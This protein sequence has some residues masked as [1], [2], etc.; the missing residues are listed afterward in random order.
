M[1]KTPANN[2]ANK[3]MLDADASQ[4]HHAEIRSFAD[5]VRHWAVARP[6]HVA[7]KH[8]DLSTTYRELDR[9]SSRIANA[10]IERGFPPGTNAGYLGKNSCLFWGVWFGAVKAR[11]TMAPFNWRCS[12]AELVEIFRDSCTPIVFVGDEFAGIAEQILTTGDLDLEIVVFD[13]S[14]PPEKSVTEFLGDVASDDPALEAMPDDGVLLS[15]TSGTTGVPKGVLATQQAFEYSH[16]CN[17]LEPDWSWTKDDRFIMS[18]PN[19]HLGGSWVTLTTLYHGAQVL[20]MPAFDPVDFMALLRSERATM[21]A[22][23]PVAI[24]MLLESEGSSKADFETLHSITYFGSPI[25]SD[26]L[27]RAQAVIDCDLKQSYGTTE[28]YFLT[29]LG[30]ADHRDAKGERLRSC[31]RPLPLVQIEIRNADGFACAPGS[32]GELFVRTPM[33]MAGYWMRPDATHEVLEDGWYRTGDLGYRDEDGYFFIVDRARDMIIS[34]GENIYSAEVENALAKLQGVAASAVIGLPDDKWGERVTA[35]IIP[36]P[37]AEMTEEM[38]TGHCRALIA[39]YKVPRQIIFVDQ[40]PMTPTGKIQ[41]AKIKAEWIAGAASGKP[42]V[43]SNRD[44]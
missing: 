7:L 41:K 16:L 11:C 15:Y 34:G 39:G 6:D 35:F 31:G 44:A 1:A 23:V 43:E 22:L 40:L 26:T 17:A 25:D 21:A 13:P 37:N 38:V 14:L 33:V 5:I 12:A 3:R 24:R 18:M 28:T 8:A 9:L 32:V 29:M 10:L 42:E 19:F 36:Q 20:I 2:T 30:S 27:M 4:W